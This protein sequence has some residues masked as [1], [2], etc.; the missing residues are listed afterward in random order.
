MALVPFIFPAGRLP[1]S[2]LEGRDLDS[3][4]QHTAHSRGHLLKPRAQRETRKLE[5]KK[6]RKKERK[7]GG[8]SSS[9]VAPDIHLV[10]TLQAAGLS[11]SSRISRWAPQPISARGAR[12]TP[13]AAGPRHQKK[14]RPAPDPTAPRA[15]RKVRGTPGESGKTTPRACAHA[16][17]ND[18]LLSN[19]F[20]TARSLFSPCFLAF[21]FAL[22][23]PN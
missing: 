6:K 12:R 1:G 14:P 13:A 21:L 5:K 19:S 17:T 3:L 9:L 16:H 10:E 4:S 8:G 22:C 2:L 20:Q 11:V 15:L 18:R 7:K 23:D